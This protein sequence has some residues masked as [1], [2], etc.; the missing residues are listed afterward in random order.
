MPTLVYARFDDAAAADRATASLTRASGS[1]PALLVQ[2]H[3]EGPL[4]GDDLPEVATQTLRNTVI[5]TAVGGVVGVVFGVL[6]ALVLGILPPGLGAG[7]GLL[8][9]LLFGVI[10][11][12]MAGT[13][14]PKPELLEA[15][16]GLDGGAVLV[17][18]E[19]QEPAHV[20]HVEE[21]LDG[22]GASLVD[23]C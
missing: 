18:I 14:V 19:V 23:R 16:A 15:A 20:D 7:L 11:G 22:H 8:T 17:M 2:H 12:V 21:L 6:A 4:N 9:G 1:L 3:T 5:G 13:R 10:H